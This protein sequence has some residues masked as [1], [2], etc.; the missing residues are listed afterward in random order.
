MCPRE[1]PT[2]RPS[3][4]RGSILA[5][6]SSKPNPSTQPGSWLIQGSLTPGTPTQCDVPQ[7]LKTKARYSVVNEAIECGPITRRGSLS[8][9]LTSPKRGAT[10]SRFDMIHAQRS[11]STCLSCSAV[12]DGRLV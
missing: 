6:S 8:P 11:L 3:R 9:T 5:P 12:H 7:M 1:G 10:P 2:Y 4:S